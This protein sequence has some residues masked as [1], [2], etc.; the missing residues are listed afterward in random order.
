MPRIDE[1]QRE[2]DVIVVGGGMSGISA[3]VAA[4]RSGASVL[5]LERLG[6][7]G[8]SATAA[9]VG[10]I[11]GLYFRSN[12]GP[13][14]AS[15][16]FPKEFSE[17]LQKETDTKPISHNE[18]L[19]FLPYEPL[20]LEILCDTII[21]EHNVALLLYSTVHTIE[22]SENIITGLKA[23]V[24]NKAIDFNTKAVVDCTGEA[25]VVSLAG[26]NTF[27]SGNYQ[28]GAL[29]FD[30]CNIEPTDTRTLQLALFKE[31]SAAIQA[32]LLPKN[33]ERLS[34]IPGSHV[35][36]KLSLKLGV[37][38]TMSGS[39]NAIT[40]ADRE[41]RA[42]ALKIIE[43]LRKKV[44]QFKSAY[45]SSM[46]SQV[47][48]RTSRLA[49]GRA[50]LKN[51][52]VLNCRK[53]KDAIANGTWPVEDWRLDRSPSM[54]Y[55]NADDCYQIP[56]GA[57]C[58]SDFENVFLAGRMISAE[59]R[60]I[61]SARVIGTCLSTGYAAGILAAHSAKSLPLDSALSVIQDTDPLIKKA[62]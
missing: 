8:G 4:G 5:L 55:F 40:Q 3:A 45:I 38:D 22:V 7:L 24:W 25:S 61:A 52:D 46:A 59:E 53:F 15:E 33:S 30:V 54:E 19:W 57:L 23:L 42:L 32:D 6:F 1:V 29:V 37:V 31:L 10:T 35:Y 44:S 34:I 62:W 18:D 47:G 26:G 60:A 28:A 49:K 13:H 12:D 11:C 36:N 50:V 43:Y 56:I 39:P 17:L 9:R 16:G 51:E 41:S 2:Y 48:V 20:K 58:S 21:K 14:Y 27:E